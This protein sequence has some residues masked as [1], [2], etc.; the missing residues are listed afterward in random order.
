MTSGITRRPRQRGEL[1]GPPGRLRSAR[2]GG[3][4]P[5]PAVQARTE[6]VVR[7]IPGRGTRAATPR[8]GESAAIPKPARPRASSRTST[9]SRSAGAPSSRAPRTRGSCGCTA[10]PWEGRN[11]DKADDERLGGHLRLRPR[12]IPEAKGSPMRSPRPPSSSP[13]QRGAR[14]LEAYPMRTEPGRRSPGARS[15]S[16]RAAC[17]PRRDSARSAGP[18]SDASSCGSTSH[19][20][21]GQPTRTRNERRHG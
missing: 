3:R 18:A 2:L 16:E 15:T 6:G 19:D 12:R 17:S 20:G 21:S 8:A 14:A 10:S 7:L 4:L 13:A 11:E 5:V 1:G 9:R